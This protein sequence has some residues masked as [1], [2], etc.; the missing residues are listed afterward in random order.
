ML[1]K[2]SRKKKKNS[3]NNLIYYT[4]DTV[5]LETNDNAEVLTMGITLFFAVI[6]LFVGSN[7][8]YKQVGLK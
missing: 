3:L 7:R 6:T 2:F 5:V 4:T 1:I 8:V